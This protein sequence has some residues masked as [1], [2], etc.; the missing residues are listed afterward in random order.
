MHTTA[1]FLYSQINARC[2][3]G[4]WH[5]LAAEKLMSYHLNSADDFT[6]FQRGIIRIHRPDQN[7]C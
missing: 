7:I 5:P 3:F 6:V 4:A 1:E 2:T